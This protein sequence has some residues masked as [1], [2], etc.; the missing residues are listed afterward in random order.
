MRQGREGSS[1]HL[2]AAA[3]RSPRLPL[4]EP[5]PA[6]GGAQPVGTRACALVGHGRGPAGWDARMRARRAIVDWGRGALRR[7]PWG[8]SADC[9]GRVGAAGRACA[10]ADVQ[11]SAERSIR[12][13]HR[14]AVSPTGRV[15]PG[16][17]L[18]GGVGRGKGRGRRHAAE[19]P[20][21]AIRGDSRV[22]VP[23]RAPGVRRA[24][25]ASSLARTREPPGGGSRPGVGIV[26]KLASRAR[27][28]HGFRARVE[29]PVELAARP[30]SWRPGPPEFPDDGWTVPAAAQGAV[31]PHPRSQTTPCLARALLGCTAPPPPSLRFR[32]PRGATL[33]PFPVGRPACDPPSP[34]VPGQPGWPGPLRRL[35]PP[36]HTHPGGRFA[37]AASSSR[38]SSSLGVGSRGTLWWSG[39]A[40]GYRS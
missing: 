28:P 16:T 25:G 31:A 23:G 34:R 6:G 19:G 32:P 36:A 35:R 15:G 12:G 2:E 8:S 18:V 1:G 14:G 39:Q 11:G 24:R 10:G 3:P 40:Q 37:A 22:P 21:A 30:R 20:S 7:R 38:F 13:A 33:S 29:S 4:P 5:L 26:G 9:R 27:G 17:G